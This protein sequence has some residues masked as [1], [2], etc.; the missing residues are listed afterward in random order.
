MQGLGAKRLAR[1]IEAA[2]IG[3]GRG[4]DRESSCGF[5]T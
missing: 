3:E 2:L 5:A 1:T 4:C